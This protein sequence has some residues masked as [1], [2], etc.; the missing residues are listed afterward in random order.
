[1][2]KK[3]YYN[4]KR[5]LLQCQKRPTTVGRLKGQKE[6]R[7]GSPPARERERERERVRARAR[8]SERLLGS[9]LHNGGSR[10]SPAGHQV[11]AC[12]C[13]CVCAFNATYGGAE[14]G[15]VAIAVGFFYSY[16]SSLLL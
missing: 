9:K 11:C 10:V 13:V 15:T 1:V 5:D 8:A 4:V 14:Q 6:Y 3:T 16:G 2:S 12:V 7:F